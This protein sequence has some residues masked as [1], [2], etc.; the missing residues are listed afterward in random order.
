M[1]DATPST[2]TPRVLADGFAFLEG[3]RWKD[4]L[5]WLSDI[6]AGTVYTLTA[7][8]ERRTVAKVPG[9]PSGIGF[10]T[11]GTP[12]VVSMTERRLMR[13]A[14]DGS[15]SV[16]ADFSALVPH[17]IND[18]VVDAKGN[19]W[20]GCMG[21]DIFAGAEHT[22]GP[23]LHAAPDG[24]VSIASEG[25]D[26]PNGPVIMA[27]GRMVV[28][29]SFGDRLSSFAI[30][31]DGKLTDRRTWAETGRTPDGI[32]LDVD[33]GIWV[34]LFEECR[35]D[36]FVDGKVVDSVAT[37]GRHAVACQLGGPNG[38]TLFC[39]TYEGELSDIQTSTNGRVEVVEV[40]AAAAGSP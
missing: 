38:R 16:H 6:G 39:L 8:G 35:F 34:S 15:L 30:G 4:G 37:P 13:I 36:R 22:L 40:A 14:P 25:I 21:Y 29:E 17:P 27:D 9:N 20:V 31:A 19:A 11:D 3:P 32:C 26:F 28:A 23:I 33:G 18:M 5:L 2:H 7:G 24:T 1:T 12:I 10:L